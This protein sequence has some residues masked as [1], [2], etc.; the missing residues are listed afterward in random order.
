MKSIIFSSSHKSYIPRVLSTGLRSSSSSLIL[1]NRKYTS[2]SIQVSNIPQLSST[3]HN[4]ICSSTNILP[5]IHQRTFSTSSSNDN[6]GSRQP[7]ADELA[8]IRQLAENIAKNIDD[9]IKELQ[10][11]YGNQHTDKVS[12]KEEEE[13]EKL[14]DIYHKY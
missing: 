5:S 14:N 12:N 8:K 11:I 10:S 4:F 6:T 2:S 9:G 7:S 13:K 1:S 3:K